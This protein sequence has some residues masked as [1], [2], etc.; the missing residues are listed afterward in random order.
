M[1]KVFDAKGAPAGEL[2]LDDDLLALNRG[3][4]AVHDAVVAHLAAE[5]AGS[6][7]TRGKGEVSGSNVKPWRQKGTGRARSGYRRSPVWRGGGIA[8][9]PHPRS[10]EQRIPRRVVQLAFRHAFSQR[11]AAGEVKVLEE[12]AVPEAKTKAFAALLKGLGTPAGALFVVDRV[13]PK[14]AMA[15]R[16]IP[17]VEMVAARDVSA[18]Q[19][20]RHR[21]I[22]VT[23]AGL[24]LL[25]LRLQGGAGRE[26]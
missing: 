2:V 11:A 24:E 6:A 15:S 4:Q 13:E 9:G 12:L 10:Y 20:L 26:A 8:H 22:V 1:L 19:I 23:K 3:R 5:R 25:K 21:A 18:Y 14:A 17:G 7:N 16:N